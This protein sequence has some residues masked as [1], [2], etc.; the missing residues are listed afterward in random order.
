MMMTTR[1]ETN[2]LHSGVEYAYKYLGLNKF[3]SYKYIHIFSGT[4]PL[5]TWN[6]QVGLW[7]LGLVL[8][9]W[10]Q[11]K[12]GGGNQSWPWRCTLHSGAPAQCSGGCHTAH[13]SGQAGVISSPCP[14]PSLCDFLP[15]LCLRPARAVMTL[16]SQG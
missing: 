10:I 8:G 12:V 16:G 13:I 7:G 1:K 9:A 5:Y 11:P 3:Q 2:Q 14:Q 4:I 15:T 6:V